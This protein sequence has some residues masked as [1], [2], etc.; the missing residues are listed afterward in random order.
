MATNFF[1]DEITKDMEIQ[2]NNNLRLTENN[3]EFVSQKLENVLMFFLGEWWLN[4]SLGIPYL[5][6]DESERNDNTKNIFVKNPDFN[7]INNIFISA[8]LGVEGVLEIEKFE[9]ELDTATRIFSLF[10]T[11]KETTGEIV[12][13]NIGTLGG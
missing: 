10:F 1:L 3:T 12:P 13:V 2:S 7:F 9:P 8:I 11:V 4:P 6:R 5:S